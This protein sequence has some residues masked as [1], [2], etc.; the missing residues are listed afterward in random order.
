MAPRPAR[1]WVCSYR[2]YIKRGRQQ[3]SLCYLFRLVP[4]SC[5]ESHSVIRPTTTGT[6]TAFFFAGGIYLPTVLITAWELHA[7][8]CIQIDVENFPEHPCR[9]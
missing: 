8:R 7:L 6:L 1:V 3:S 4:R 5:C 2:G 9:R